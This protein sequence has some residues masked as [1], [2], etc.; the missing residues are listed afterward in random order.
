[1]I[2]VEQTIRFCFSL[3]LFVSFEVH[4]FDLLLSAVRLF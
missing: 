2:N 4:A 1:M 3:V